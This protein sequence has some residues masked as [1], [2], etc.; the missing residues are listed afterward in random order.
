MHRNERMMITRLAIPFAHIYNGNE[1]I[2]GDSIAKGFPRL[3]H[4]YIIV[5][6]KQYDRQEAAKV[7]KNISSR[8]WP[9]LWFRNLPRAMQDAITA[10]T[11]EKAAAEAAEKA[12]EKA[13]MEAAKAAK[14]AAK[15]AEE[16]AKRAAYA[17][18]WWAKKGLAIRSVSLSSSSSTS[19]NSTSVVS[20]SNSSTSSISAASTSDATPQ[21]KPRLRVQPEIHLEYIP[22]HVAHAQKI[23][24]ASEFRTRTE[25]HTYLPVVLKPWA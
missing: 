15:K 18:A 11:A 25:Y 20:T 3:Q 17:D 12:A 19:S 10:D 22:A 14:E 7:W 16:E 13:A 6:D 2:I 1:T 8:W 23:D 5:A 4:L 24:L 21:Q 9:N